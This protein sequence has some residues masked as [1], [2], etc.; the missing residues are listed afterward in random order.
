MTSRPEFSLSPRCLTRAV[1]PAAAGL[2]VALA[3]G[4]PA[5]AAGF[6][7]AY[8]KLDLD[9]CEVLKEYEEGGG[10]DLKCP[11]YQDIPVFASEGDLRF[12]VDFG[13]PGEESATFGPFNEPGE[14]IEWRLA[15]GKPFATILRFHLDPGDGSGKI[16]DVLAVYTLSGEGSCPVGYVDASVNRDA[17]VLARQIADEEAQGFVCGSDRPKYRGKFSELG[18]SASAVQQ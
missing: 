4:I 6:D 11:G 9:S 18:G 5:S 17:N 8:T 14:T 7:S 12:S 10:V 3:T 2:F 13:A 16:T 15:G 1:L